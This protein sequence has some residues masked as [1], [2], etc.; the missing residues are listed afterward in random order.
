MGWVG[1]VCKVIFMSNL[2]SVEVV[3]GCRWGCDKKLSYGWS[4]LD[5]KITLWLHLAS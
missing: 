5:H 4:N 3:L 2:T 1:L